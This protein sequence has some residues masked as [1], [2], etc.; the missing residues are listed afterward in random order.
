[1]VAKPMASLLRAMINLSNLPFAGL[2][3]FIDGVGAWEVTAKAAAEVAAVRVCNNGVS[4]VACSAVKVRLTAIARV[5]LWR[6]QNWNEAKKIMDA[7]LL[8]IS[9]LRKV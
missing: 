9:L 1:M 2:S 3:G 8:K 7:L 4:N 5:Y 6:T